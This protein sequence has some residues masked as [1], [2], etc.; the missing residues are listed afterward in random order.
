MVWHIGYFCVLFHI[1]V[2]GI[3]ALVPWHQFVYTIFMPCGRLLFNQVMTAFFRSSSIA[4]RLPA[5]CPV[6]LEIGKSPTVPDPDC[7]EDARRCPN[8]IVHAVS[9]VSAGQYADVHCCATEQFHARACLFGKI[10]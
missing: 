5:T 2:F 4:K 7:N 10:T 8:G 6:I 3:T 9:L 1:V